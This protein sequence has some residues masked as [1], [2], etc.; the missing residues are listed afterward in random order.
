MVS[1]SE[2]YAKTLDPLKAGQ[3]AEA[4]KE[5]HDTFTPTVKKLYSEAAQIYPVRS[6]KSE[7]WCIWTRQFYVQ[8]IKLDETL[9]KGDQAEALKMLAA[10]REHINNLHEQAH[11]Q[12]ANDFIYA[13]HRQLEQSAPA[14]GELSALAD[15]LAKAD[16]SAKAKANAEA[17]AKARAE[18]SRQATAALADGRLASGRRKA[19]RASTEKFYHDYG[20]PFE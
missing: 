7:N 20:L 8:T 17:Y 2:S 13:F 11:V 5:F 9:G 18:W 6:S 1:L 15:K 3:T 19:L 16:P 10:L 14:A 12:K 4:A